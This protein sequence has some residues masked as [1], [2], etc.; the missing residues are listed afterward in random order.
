[1]DDIQPV[2]RMLLLFYIGNEGFHRR[3]IF[4]T[5]SKTPF[6]TSHFIMIYQDTIYFLW[7][8]GNLP[9]SYKNIHYTNNPVQGNIY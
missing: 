9:S 6:N 7:K 8:P 2:T 1:M 5:K 3:K 4:K